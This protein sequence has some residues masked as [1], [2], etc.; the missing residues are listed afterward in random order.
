MKQSEKKIPGR[1]LQN[2]IMRVLLILRLLSAAGCTTTKPLPPAEKSLP[3]YI[4]ARHL[5]FIGLDGWGGAY[6]SRANMPV[7]ERMIA[8]GASS[9]DMRCVMP[10]NSWPNWTALFSGAPL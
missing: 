4:P 2:F 10:S 7:T 8:G 5:V 3:A 1:R 6:A 9:L